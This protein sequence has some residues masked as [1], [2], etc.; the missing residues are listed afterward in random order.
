MSIKPSTSIGLSVVL[1]VGV[2]ALGAWWGQHNAA[3]LRESVSSAEQATSPR[4]LGSKSQVPLPRALDSEPL[5]E[6]MI[7]SPS[8]K[9]SVAGAAGQPPK[10]VPG[11]VVAG[12][13][14]NR[15]WETTAIQPW[16]VRAVPIT[17]PNWIITG[18]VQRGKNTQII[19]QFDGE[20]A[21][22]F[23]KIG[24]VLPGGSTLAWVG[25]G[26]IGV[27]TPNRKRLAVP[28]LPNIFEPAASA[29]PGQKP[30]P[31]PTSR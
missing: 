7:S 30:T 21:P 15:L 3:T 17:A 5:Q 20:P 11:G 22:R 1:I 2:G 6:E 18:V 25:P 31:T 19:V 14:F 4:A 9:G 23:L 26:T 12:S 27:V 8:S 29:S 24:D 16:Q 13:D 10:I 28:V